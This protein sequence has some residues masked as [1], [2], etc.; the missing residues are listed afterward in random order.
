MNP[1]DHKI[2]ILNLE[3]TSYPSRDRE[4]ATLVCNYLRFQGCH[5]VEDSIHRGFESLLR[6]RPKLLFLTNIGGARINVKVARFAS[7]LGIPVVTTISEGNL[8]TDHDISTLIWGNNKERIILE[9]TWL[10]WNDHDKE[11]IL[12]AVPQYA[13][14]IKISGAVGFDRYRICSSEVSGDKINTKKWSFVVGVG[15][16]NFGILDVRDYRYPVVK[17][18]IGEN[19]IKR[20]LKDRDRFNDILVN[21]IRRNPDIFFLLKE[22]PG[23]QLGFWASGIEDCATE[24]NVLVIKN[25][26]SIFDCLSLS[27]IWISYES[28]TALE[29]WLMGKPTALLNPSGTDFPLRQQI[30]MGQPN[31]PNEGLF[32][33]A[34]QYYRDNHQLPG[35]LELTD[36]RKKII[37]EII[38]WDD[39]LNHVRVGNEI[40]NLLETNKNIISSE[41]PILPP[42]IAEILRHSLGWRKAQLVKHLPKIFISKRKDPRI[43]NENEIRLFADKRMAQQIAFYEKNGLDKKKLREVRAR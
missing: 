19:N 20:F 4:S 37:H 38:Q 13:N 1:K 43:W 9:K 8:K 26:W 23:T 6:Y 2:D 40:I 35:F 42:R 32:Q 3:W 36:V 34:L 24:P 21:I 17:S 16:W 29:M 30:W 7:S 25:E 12:S 41:P 11:T 5:V 18:V 28:T 22:H 27:D 10:V 31:Y 14:R 39:G 15:C 33:K